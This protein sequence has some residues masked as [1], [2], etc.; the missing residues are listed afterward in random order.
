MRDWYLRSASM[1]PCSGI[2]G[3]AARFS[4]DSGLKFNVKVCAGVLELIHHDSVV[5]RNGRVHFLY[6]HPSST[7]KTAWCQQRYSRE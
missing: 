3:P 5:F 7:A 6:L 4:P 1:L 2:E